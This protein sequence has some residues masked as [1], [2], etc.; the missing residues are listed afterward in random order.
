MDTSAPVS[1]EK[2][3]E[4][5]RFLAEQ[6]NGK[7][8]H[9]LGALYLTG[10]GVKKNG[11]EAIKW[12]RQAALRGIVLSQHNLG[13]IYLKGEVVE[14]NPVEADKWFR[15]AAEQGDHR[16]QHNLG[17]MLFEGLGMEKDLVQSYFWL[18]M[19]VEGVPKALKD[20]MAMIRDQVAEHL[21][22]DQLREA[23]D[24]VLDRC[25]FWESGLPMDGF[26]ADDKTG[27]MDENN[28]SYL[29]EV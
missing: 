16:S 2:F 27:E 10:E 4:V 24:W 15:M 11:S 12:F 22:D 18:S 1:P 13:A 6:G 14:Q 20:K 8:Q 23:Q 29:D 3:L 9:N 26:D 19:A 21:D 28:G 5:L 7:A 17:A 25:Q